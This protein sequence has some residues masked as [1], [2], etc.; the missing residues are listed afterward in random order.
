MEVF[1]FIGILAC[2]L[3]MLAAGVFLTYVASEVVED[4][5]HINNINHRVRSTEWKVEEILRILK[6]ENEVEDDDDE[7]TD[8]SQGAGI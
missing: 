5:H 3:A 2:F 7:D 1:T 8:D 6:D 4:H